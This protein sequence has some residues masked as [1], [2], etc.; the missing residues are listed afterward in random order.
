[1]RL[2]RV[3]AARFR[4]GA[5][6]RIG[7]R[8]SQPRGVS[9]H[10]DLLPP[11]ESLSQRSM[12]AHASAHSSTFSRTRST[13][14]VGAS[15]PKGNKENG[16]GGAGNELGGRDAKRP[17]LH[18]HAPPHAPPVDPNDDDGGLGMTEERQANVC[19]G[20]GQ[21]FGGNGSSGS[22]G[23][24]EVSR[25][26]PAPAAVPTLKK[27]GNAADEPRAAAPAARQ[28]LGFLS[29]N[30]GATISQADASRKRK[31][32]A[33]ANG[34]NGAAGDKRFGGAENSLRI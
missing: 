26:K 29:A 7:A 31:P 5:L 20:L 2:V 10:N 18:P 16:G 21:M 27:G 33:A 24:I 30:N 9:A 28:P 4:I 32:L 23:S 6:L 25:P 8:W 34:G 12:A 11:W 3:V 1:M 19:A 22:S 17:R 15:S 13:V 14:K